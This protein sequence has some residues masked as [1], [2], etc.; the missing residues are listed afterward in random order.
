M[1]NDWFTIGPLTIHGY[2]VMIAVGIFLAFWLAEKNAKKHGLDPEKVDNI[3]FV[4]LVG[5]FFC[6]KVLYCLT[7]FDQF[8]ADPLSVLGA[9]GWVVYGGI[10]GAI[11]SMYLYCKKNGLD[12]MHYFNMLIPY[13]SM[14]QGFG[15]IGCFLAG[16]CYGVHTD[17]WYGITFP[18]GSLAPAGVSLVPTQLIMSAGNF[19][20][21]AILFWNMNHGKHPEYNA[22]I[23][24]MLYSAGR[25]AVEFLRGDAIRGSIGPFSTSQFIG[26]FVFHAGAWLVYRTQKKNSTVL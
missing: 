5:G 18:E 1:W 24:M 16:C 21:C 2:G 13:A 7:V 23:F 19:L 12:F 9:G 11:G 15:R 20:I 4:L 26:F 8:I 17:A 6:S 22:G 14:S 10:L 25:F 3:V